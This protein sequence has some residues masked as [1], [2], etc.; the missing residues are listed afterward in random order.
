MQQLSQVKKQLDDEVQH[1]TNSYSQLRAALQK[2]RDCIASVVAGVA[3]ST[4]DKPLLVPLT[5]SLYVPGTLA[6]TETVLVDVGTGFFVEKT[7]DQ[8]KAFYERKAEELAKNI[9][10]LE[11]IVNQKGQNLRVVEEGMSATAAGYTLRL[12]IVSFKSCVKRFWQAINP[13]GVLH[14]PHEQ[15]CLDLPEESTGSATSNLA[16]SFRAKCSGL[17]MLR[18]SLL[19]CKCSS[20]RASEGHQGCIHLEGKHTTSERS[21]ENM[22]EA[23]GVKLEKHIP[24]SSISC[25]IAQPKLS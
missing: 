15:A 12:L 9:K 16:V 19:V 22:D 2:F 8:A 20:P 10:D 6:S 18:A 7:T 25:C 23:S 14:Q 13:L 17:E 3:N 1:L 11:T 21:Q 24:L 5:S 4:A